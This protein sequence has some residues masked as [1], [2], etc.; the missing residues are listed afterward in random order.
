MC[1]VG[2]CAVPNNRLLRTV[3]RLFIYLG[4][5]TFVRPGRLYT[6]DTRRPEA[7]PPGRFTTIAPVGWECGWMMPRFAAWTSSY[8]DQARRLAYAQTQHDTKALLLRIA[9]N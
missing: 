9:Q 4:E 5:Y 3:H 6:A 8:R 1:N 2:S 7:G